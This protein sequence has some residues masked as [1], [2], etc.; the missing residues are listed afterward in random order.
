M[1]PRDSLPGRLFAPNLGRCQAVSIPATSRQF[2]AFPHDASRFLII[3]CCKS[4]TGQIPLA[5]KSFGEA[6]DAAVARIV[7]DAERLGVTMSDLCESA[8]V[9][10]TTPH[11]YM[12]RR[13]ETVENIVAL[14][15]EI[16]K[17]KRKGASCQR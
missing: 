5:R 15:N 8:G 4:G 10:R 1:M 17:H 13:P 12:K 2:P 9:S 7:A 14:E 3:P 11:R 6:F 16:A